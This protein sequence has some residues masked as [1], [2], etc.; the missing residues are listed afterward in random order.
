MGK[1]RFQDRY[2][3]VGPVSGDEVED[4]GKGDGEFLLFGFNWGG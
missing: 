4:E 2:G 3:D 1:E